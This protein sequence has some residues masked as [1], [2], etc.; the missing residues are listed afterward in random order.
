M[1]LSVQSAINVPTYRNLNTSKTARNFSE[2][3]ECMNSKTNN[4]LQIPPSQTLP[5]NCDLHLLFQNQTCE[6]TAVKDRVNSYLSLGD[7]M[8]NREQITDLYA[9]YDLDHLTT[10]DEKD[11]LDELVDLGVITNDD[12]NFALDITAPCLPGTGEGVYESWVPME[13]RHVTPNF[14]LD[15]ILNGNGSMVQKLNQKISF[16]NTTIAWLSDENNRGIT[17]NEEENCQRLQNYK[18]SGEKVLNV[19]KTLETI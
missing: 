15:Y 12:K 3:A 8:I 10:K 13:R 14:S 19:M 1:S 17:Q 18:E 16:C 2:F 6:N 4:P 5:S 7:A 11:L 9:R